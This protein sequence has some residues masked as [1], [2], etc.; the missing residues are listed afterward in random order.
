[1]TEEVNDRI[2]DLKK[3]FK[4]EFIGFVQAEISSLE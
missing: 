3:Y 1:M 4:E 2:K